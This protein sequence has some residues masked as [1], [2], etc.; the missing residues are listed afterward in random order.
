MPRRTSSC[1]ALTRSSPPLPTA[2]LL[3][4]LS[5][6]LAACPGGDDGTGDTGSMASGTTAG[7][8][9]SAGTVDD[10]AGTAGTAGPV[11]DCSFDEDPWTFVDALDMPRMRGVGEEDRTCNPVT[12]ETITLQVQ[13]VVP[14]GVTPSPS[15]SVRVLL[16]EADPNVADT[17]ADCVGGLCESLDGS[18]LSWSFEVP[19]DQPELT[20]YIVAD[21]DVDGPD[22]GC[23][24]RETDFVTFSPAQGTL[25][26]P[27]TA[28]GCI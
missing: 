11:A 19:N 8:T 7:G 15:G 22:G 2:P 28:D 16:F 23:T 13:L 26:V 25:M 9:A 6:A 4:A 14:E 21:V 1:P 10:T 20:Y 24:L 17:S 5:L 18:T 27:M 3:A 12:T